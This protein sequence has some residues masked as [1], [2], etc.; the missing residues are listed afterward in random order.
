MKRENVTAAEVQERHAT[1]EWCFWGAESR[2]CSPP[3]TSGVVC[4]PGGLRVER[5]TKIHNAASTY[6]ASVWTI[7]PSGRTSLENT[8]T[9]Q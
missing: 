8:L 1:I 3:L 6:T 4:V 7:A 9:L 5:H 2:A